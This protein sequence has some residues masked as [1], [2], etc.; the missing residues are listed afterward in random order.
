MREV[1]DGSEMRWKTLAQL[2]ES[3]STGRLA[4]ENPGQASPV[5]ALQGVPGEGVT[6]LGPGGKALGSSLVITQNTGGYLLAAKQVG[7]VEVWILA[8]I[9]GR[10]SA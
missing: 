4:L 5:A 10:V 1:V 8:G 6:G 3:V 9:P 2:S 7:R